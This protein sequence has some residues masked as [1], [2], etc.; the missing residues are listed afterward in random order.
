LATG[1][2]SFAAR[3]TRPS[4]CD[5]LSRFCAR[6]VLCWFAFL[7]VPALRSTNSATGCPALFAGFVATM[8][9]SDFSGSCIIGFDSSSSRCGPTVILRWPN[10]R[11]PD[12]R[13]K[14]V[15]TCQGLRPRRV[16]QALALTRP[17]M[18]PSV[19]LTTSAPETIL[20]S[21][22]HGWPMRSP[23]DA[24]PSPSRVPTHG[25]GPMWLAT[26]SSWRTC[27]SYSLPVLIGAP[28]FKP[29]DPLVADRSLVAQSRTRT[30]R[31]RCLGPL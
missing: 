11:S 4:A 20:L 3:R 31:C 24:S 5:T 6:H 16:G 18:L 7:P 12:S 22:L 17:S 29:S 9:Q 27:T 21:R 14:S 28:E 10:P 2:I 25:S 13:T 30:D 19:I 23:A 26:P 15:H 1:S 8:A